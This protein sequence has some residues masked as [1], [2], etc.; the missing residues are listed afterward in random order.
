MNENMKSSDDRRFTGTHFLIFIIGFFTVVISANVI[1]AY[2]A[3]D[4]FPGLE[5]EDAYRKGRD[6]NQTLE[7]ARLQET[8]GW[9]DEISLVKTGSGV[10]A[11]H[12]ITLTLKGAEA[13]TGL[14]VTLLLRRPATD[15]YDQ[16]L[17]LVETKPATFEAVVKSLPLG[18]WKLSLI[19]ERGEQIVFKKNRELLV[20][21]E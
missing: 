14:K 1:M 8:L 13:E 3:I 16:N 15:D 21:E 11:S 12:H 4:T 7:A 10:S 19:A 5:T 6:Y 17:S 18:G 20:T 9:R 2:F